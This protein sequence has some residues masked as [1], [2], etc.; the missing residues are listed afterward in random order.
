MGHGG[1]AGQLTSLLLSSASYRH[2]AILRAAIT[3]GVF[4]AL[5]LSGQEAASAGEVAKRC[6][7]SPR[8]AEKLLGGLVALGIVTMEGGRYRNTPAAAKYLIPGLNSYMG[9][10]MLF[11]QDLGL[12][13][14][15]TLTEAVRQG[16][17]GAEQRTDQPEASFWHKLT[18]AIIPL[19]EPVAASLAAAAL[20][21]ETNGSAR[22]DHD[23][24]AS[25]ASSSEALRD[26]AVIKAPPPVARSH[27][28]PDTCSHRPN[29][30]QTAEGKQ[31]H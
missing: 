14:W 23:A 10:G 15:S 17:P 21:T 24:A 1:S 11:L 13:T 6:N 18:T 5:D 19:T 2:S 29:M 31:T 8:G 20:G 3:L 7:L 26:A 22:R 28:D 9:E 16:T 27:A 4:P 25:A 30:S 12:K